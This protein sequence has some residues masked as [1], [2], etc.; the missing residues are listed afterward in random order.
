MNPY[1]DSAVASQAGGI[2]AGRRSR[3]GTGPQ[4]LQDLHL[5]CIRDLHNVFRFDNVIV[6]VRY[7]ALAKRKHANAGILDRHRSLIVRPPLLTPNLHAVGSGSGIAQPL[8]IVHPTPLL[9]GLFT[10]PVSDL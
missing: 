9:T 4:T 8:S 5:G 7:P 1:A 6:R 3:S 2:L 10:I